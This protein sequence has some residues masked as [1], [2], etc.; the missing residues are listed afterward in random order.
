MLAVNRDALRHYDIDIQYLLG[1]IS[2]NLDLEA[3]ARTKFQGEELLLEVKFEDA[4]VFDIKAL[5][6]LVIRTQENQR[7]RLADLVRMETRK[8]SGG[9]DR[10]DQQYMVNVRWDY[11]GSAKKARKFNE[12]VFSSLELPPGF[13]AELDFTEFL[14]REESANLWFVAGMAYY[15]Q[16]SDC[17][18]LS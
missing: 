12:A 17:T 11:R 4:D 14:S 18:F 6:S 2:R 7:I 13:K 8:V 5:E 10:K 1:F 3:R 16:R 9:I 15:N